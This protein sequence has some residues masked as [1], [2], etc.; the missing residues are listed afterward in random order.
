MKSREN[1]NTQQS[2]SEGVEYFTKN[3]Y[4]QKTILN[5]IVKFKFH[6]FSFSTPSELFLNL[7]I[8]SPSFTRCYSNSTPS[9][10]I[11]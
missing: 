11:I 3:I 8:L 1:E 5:K 2:N 10:L 4:Y 9:E 7:L 6:V